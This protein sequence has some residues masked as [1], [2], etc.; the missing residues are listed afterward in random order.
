[1]TVLAEL[2]ASREAAEEALRKKV[3]DLNK[4]VSSGASA[5]SSRLERYIAA[6]ESK[7]EDYEHAH[8]ALKAKLSVNAQNPTDC[9]VTKLK[10]KFDQLYRAQQ[11][12]V[13]EAHDELDRRK[14]TEEK[15][16]LDEAPDT[17]KNNTS[18]VRR[19]KSE[20][21]LQQDVIKNSLT[22][23]KASL[24][25]GSV[26]AQTLKSHSTVL[27]KESTDMQEVIIPLYKQIIE[28]MNTQTEEEAIETER[29]TFV[30]EV[31]NS[32]MEI[33]SD[34][35]VAKSAVVSPA[36]QQATDAGVSG[37]S[38]SQSSRGGYFGYFN[39]KNFPDFSG[40]YRDYPEFR[41][42]WLECVQPKYE[43]P[44]QRHEIM[45][46]VP[47]MMRPVLRNCENMV[48]V[49]K[50]LDEEY[51]NNIDICPEVIGE[52]TSFKFSS[53]SPTQQ[54]LELYN[55]YN[56]AKQDLKQVNK[57]SELNNLTTLRMISEK[58]PGEL[59]KREYAKDR[60]AKKSQI[61]TTELDI[62]DSF[63]TEQYKVEKEKSK[64]EDNEQVRQ[65]KFFRGHCNNCSGYGHKTVDCPSPGNQSGSAGGQGGGNKLGAGQG[66]VVNHIGTSKQ[67][68]P[69]PACNNQHSIK[70]GNNTMYRTSLY[71]CDSFKNLSPNER[72][73]LVQTAGGCA[74]CLDWTGSHQRDKCSTKLGRKQIPLSN[75][76]VLDT[77]TNAKCGKKHHTMLHG[78]TN[79][80]CNLVR[81]CRV[82]GP[83]AL[84]PPPNQEDLLAARADVMLQLQWV[85]VKTIQLPTTVQCL[86]FWDNGATIALV[87]ESF[88][89][90]LGLRGTQCSQWIQTAGRQFEKWD[91]T[92]YFISL[93]DR[94]GNVHKI[95]AYSI[96][97]I[98]SSVE[99]V[100]V[101]GLVHHFSKIGVP[102]QS[103]ARPH[104]EVDLL[105][106]LQYAA[107]HP[108]CISVVGQLRLL[109]SQFGSGYLLDG[110][111]PAL[112]SA[113]VYVNSTAHKYCHSIEVLSSS[114]VYKVNLIKGSKVTSKHTPMFL[115]EEDEDIMPFKAGNKK[116]D[117]LEAEQL[118][119]YLPKRCSPCQSCPRCSI[120][121]QKMSRR[122]QAQL[123]AIED[124]IEF[125][126]VK[127]K[128]TANYPY[129][130]DPTVLTDNYE[131]ARKI[132]AGIE[133]QIIRKGQLEK[134]NEQL[135]D[136]VKRG[137]IVKL[138]QQDLESWDGLV[139]YITH[140]AVLKPGSTTTPVRVVSNSSLDNNWS[141]VSYNDCLAKGPNSLTPLLEVL[142]T[143]RTYQ[144]CVVWDISKA[145]NAIDA[146]EEHWHMRRLLWRWGVTT[147]PWSVYVLRYVHF[148]DRPAGMC[149]EI[150]KDLAREAG[151]D[152]CPETAVVMEKGSYV[153]DSI[154]GGS[155]EFIDKLV[156]EVTEKNDKY[157][158]TGTVSQI[159]QQV[160]MS[161]KV[162]VRS[163][164]QNQ[165]AIDKLGQHLLGHE[166]K[167]KEDILVFNIAV[168]L[169]NKRGKKI[170][171]QADITPTTLEVLWSS[172][173][174]LRIL[175]GVISSIYDPLGLLTPLTI[176]WKIELGELH[177]GEVVQW[178]TALEG[179]LEK[180]WKEMLEM[181]VLLP[182]LVFHRSANPK[183][184]KGSPEIFGYFD[185]GAKAFG[186][187]VYL[188]YERVN[189]GPHGETHDVRLLGA[190]AR[191]GSRTI[192]KQE[193]DGCLV[194]HRFITA[195]LPGMVDA[196]SAIN[197]IGDSSAAITI[198]DC[199]HKILTP[200]FDSRVGEIEEHRAE[201]K[202]HAPVYP[203]FHTPGLIN[204]ADICT[205]GKGT[206]SDIAWG[207]PWQV[208]PAY[209]LYNDRTVWPISRTFSAVVPDECKL[210]RIYTLRV[211]LD[212]V[213]STIA[214]IML[215]SD[216]LS[217]V[218][219]II[220]R[221]IHACTT[222]KRE[223]ILEAP[224]VG[225][226]QVAMK[227]ML[228]SAMENTRQALDS[229][230]LR[231]LS[232]F[233]QKGVCVTEGRLAKGLV[234]VLG[235]QHL[236]ILMR[237]SRLAY[238]VMLVAHKKNHRSP[239]ITLHTSR[240]MGYWIHYGM[241][242]AKKVCS[243]CIL[244]IT[245]SKVMAEQRMSCL[246]MERV[247]L[248]LPPW[249]NVCIDL[250]APVSVRAMVNSR[251]SMKCW[252][253]VVV[254]MQTGATHI[255]LAH[256]YGTEAFLL[257]WSGFTALR[258]HPKLVISDRGSQLVS[259][260]AKLPWSKK[261]DPSSWDWSSIAA[262]SARHHTTWKFVPPGSQ[263]RNGLAESRVK[264]AKH[265][266]STVLQETA[267]TYAEMVNLLYRVANIINDRPLGVKTLTNDDLVPLTANH[268]L[269]GR[270]ASHISHH[271][272]IEELTE[273]EDINLTHR[274]A[275]MQSLLKAWWD[276]Y[277]IQVFPNLLPFRKYKDSQR[278]RNFQ[279]GD[280]CFLKYDSKVQP[281]YRLC[282]VVKV[283]PD[284]TG[285]V[286]TVEVALRPRNKKEKLLPYKSKK[287]FII[288]VG[289]QRLA[290]LVPTD[291]LPE[292]QGVESGGEAIDDKSVI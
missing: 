193:I 133:S 5:S 278:H 107:L 50:V 79:Q 255:M 228:F 274:Q 200:Y 261:E 130:R 218:Q 156:G 110:H 215:R 287:P 15:V 191:I 55:K 73:N 172:K 97:V 71:F 91:T 121:G 171:V 122:D 260:A 65:S 289:V 271:D 199:E 187:V 242:L 266:L 272:F 29:D 70:Q 83:P 100:Q 63:M 145:Y 3:E 292:L 10:E 74:L 68:K 208:G 252:P 265:T 96:T 282:R 99:A 1:M 90:R 102:G 141:G 115:G 243:S 283:L 34:I 140:H 57:L 288:P 256:N 158:Y 202:K 148:G 217:K 88:A 128:C 89:T 44:Y 47:E 188:R 270:A 160:G 7:W 176:K 254:C 234:P 33:R 220:A 41:R 209:L 216:S 250:M 52:L 154:A 226:L 20:L 22:S 237:H 72:A 240:L 75:C 113:P 39:K 143:W 58:L 235:V 268:L 118:G 162:M 45:Q 165:G 4:G 134:Y 126:R 2:E 69:C 206:A 233:W 12:S 168:N 28:L 13:D 9:P 66:K 179:I 120:R 245:R 6:V 136:A 224:T 177:K 111:H 135:E 164:E 236:I 183:G 119:T 94:Q 182:E 241:S 56:H 189:P 259:A 231:C 8:Y 163:G 129:I 17:I 277:Y 46:C 285:T 175:L 169:A 290:L 258:G 157:S 249:T 279:Q 152:I 166:W 124:G 212:E 253:V 213:F 186:A 31:K 229:N 137:L 138:S 276:L 194:L 184:C 155:E 273:S 269:L 127:K 197:I 198:L 190:K 222:G 203:V 205:K 139:N 112:P 77:N 92:A 192:P 178:D 43:D 48:E 286:R 131:Q 125:D 201:W 225:K 146:T 267:L 275:Y 82:A 244:C 246:P 144:N 38:T 23:I 185:G 238:L 95:V 27:D 104:G 227:L 257:Q 84:D 219:G 53:R 37:S 87:R 214:G 211:K 19:L 170:K 116:M 40:K 159:Y 86:T 247:G 167:P 80:F 81:S 54:F 230:K 132:Q 173:L 174:S 180:Q 147:K 32:I 161:L 21:K 195:I 204:P 223:S 61:G 114:E 142:T 280:V 24:L 49:W 281:S 284:D 151:K 42:Y 101:D 232:P 25:A 85:S 221:Y 51:G 30:V 210:V 251:A 103:L 105:V 67:P 98:T 36:P 263:W 291:E 239:K 181:M 106:G 123:K 78:T 16:K 11:D 149:L 207:S 109:T 35:S 264:A 59:L 60:A 262:E 18:K 62:F 93:V 64:F 196:P 76:S 150:V 108:R 117:F 14:V 26:S 153:D 248:Q